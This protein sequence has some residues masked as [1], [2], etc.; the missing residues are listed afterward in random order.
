MEEEKGEVQEE[1]QQDQ[2][3]EDSGWKSGDPL[4]NHPRFK[5]VYG[6]RNSARE[7]LKKWDEFGSMDEVKERLDRLEQ[8]EAKIKE[9]RERQAMTDEE[10]NQLASKERIRKQMLDVYPELK[11]LERFDE[12]TYDSR[13]VSREEQNWERASETLGKILKANNI[14]VDRNGQDD[15]ED[16]ILSK[17]SDEERQSVSG[18]NFS[19]IQGIYDRA[20]KSPLFSGLSSSGTQNGSQPPE[21]PPKR[22]KPGGTTAKPPE[23][24]ATT[25][26]EAEKRAFAKMKSEISGG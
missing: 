24:K 25:W 11:K 3:Q 6:E 18:G 14:N 12:A 9:V 4:D 17:M 26:E 7:S 19:I 16:F 20:S 23:K 2:Q 8:Y 22:L 15:I 1:Q 10:Q 21:S 5:E 13:Y